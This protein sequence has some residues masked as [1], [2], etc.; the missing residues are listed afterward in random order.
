MKVIIVG[1][2]FGWEDAPQEGNVWGVNDLFLRRDVNLLFNM[3]DLDYLMEYERSETLATINYVNKHNMP[4]ITL[5]KW[6]SVPTSK[7][8]P[9][10][11]MHSDFFTNSIA[12]MLAYAEYKGAT[13][14]DIYGVSMK[15]PKEYLTQKYSLDYWL[16]YV[17]GRGVKVTIHG[18]T[19]VGRSKTGGLYGYSEESNKEEGGVT[20]TATLGEGK[21]TNVYS[22][23]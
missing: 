1:K 13:E 16:G 15:D 8:F 11:K 19:L 21:N 18:E 6:N 3:H 23:P 17:R 14:I 9:L 5:R 4:L 12:Y 10:D 20:Q 22:L 2:G 7:A